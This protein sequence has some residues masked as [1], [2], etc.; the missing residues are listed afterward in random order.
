MLTL[1]VFVY[2]TLGILTLNHG[3]ELNS[4]NVMLFHSDDIGILG[5]IKKWKLCSNKDHS[6]I[7]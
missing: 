1:S 5:Y 2:D 7:I 3:M 6:L 4:N